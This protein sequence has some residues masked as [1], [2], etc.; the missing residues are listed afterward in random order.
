MEDKKVMLTD[1]MAVWTHNTNVNKLG[2]SLLQLVTGQ[3]C[4][5]PGLIMGNVAT[6]R[7]SDM[8][9]VQKVI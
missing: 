9:A 7:S 6:E 8:E 4:V 3:S 1:S 5:F 2:Y